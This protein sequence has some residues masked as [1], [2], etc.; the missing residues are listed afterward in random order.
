MTIN[1]PDDLK[2]F[3]LAEVNNGHF[4]LEEAALA[5]AVR[6]LRSQFSHMGVTEGATKG[7]ANGG[8]PDPLI[9]AFS[10]AAEEMDEIVKEAMRNRELEAWRLP[11]G[12]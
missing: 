8:G 10:D 4:A 7:T 2:N 3:I 1:L 11:S 12:E 6:L 9:G 5:E